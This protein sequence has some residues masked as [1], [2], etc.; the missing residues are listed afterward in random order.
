M[1]EVDV[2]QFA[3]WG[4]RVESGGELIEAVEQGFPFSPI[5]VCCPVRTQVLYVG[6]W[7]SLT[8]VFRSFAFWP[9]GVLQTAL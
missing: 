7:G 6:E 8:P 2:Q 9:A 5:V 3:V 4:L 1:N